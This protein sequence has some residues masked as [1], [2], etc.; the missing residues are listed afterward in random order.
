MCHHYVAHSAQLFFLP[1]GAAL[2]PHQERDAEL[3][4]SI[5]LGFLK[6]PFKREVAEIVKIIRTQWNAPPRG[7]SCIHHADSVIQCF[8]GVVL[9]H[10]HRPEL[11]RVAYA[12]FGAAL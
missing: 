1:Y 9:A 2:H 12:G 5:G 7:C 4:F 10:E 8:P 11:E 3:F 6:E